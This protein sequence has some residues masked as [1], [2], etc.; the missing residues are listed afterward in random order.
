MYKEILEHV[1]GVNFDSYFS[2]IIDGFGFWEKYLNKTLERLGLALVIT[3]NELGYI[4]CEINKLA[5][6]S[7]LQKE[8]FDFWIKRT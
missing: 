7:N 8:L 2:E 5:E 1:A 4:S 3:K 6:P